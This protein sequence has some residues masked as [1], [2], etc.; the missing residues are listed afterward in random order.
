VTGKIFIE[1][2]EG[3]HNTP[4]RYKAWGNLGLYKNLNTV[5]VT[6]T[7]G[8]CGTRVAF[9]WINVMNPPNSCVA[10]MNVEGFEVGKAYNE[11]IVAILANPH[12][13]KFQYLL[14]V[15]EDN[16]PPSDGLLKLFESIQK[17]DVVGGL[18]WIKGEGGVP[19][20]WGDP[21]EPGT[22]VPQTPIQ[23]SLQECN[24]LGMG[25]TLFRLDMFRNPGFEFGNW[26]KTVGEK[27]EYKTQDLYFF[28][29]AQKLG[30][31]FA[32]DTR[33]RVGHYDQLSGVIW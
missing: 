23:D 33:V 22:F 27:G 19:M 20:I 1:N 2:Y 8:T 32:C 21:K 15:E 13:A 29:R 24:G 28:E 25:F 7:R 10:K 4:E 31:K 14:T 11:A 3:V 6:P 17:Y 18:Y 26:F 16:C 5:W 9:S 30:Y 12:L